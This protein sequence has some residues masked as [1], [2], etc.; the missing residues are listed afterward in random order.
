MNG[1]LVQP[2]F[3]LGQESAGAS[4]LFHAAAIANRLPDKMCFSN[5]LVCALLHQGAKRPH[6]VGKH[7]ILGPSRL[8]TREPSQD[9]M[10]HIDFFKQSQC[11]APD[12]T[13][14]NASSL[15]TTA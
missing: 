1:R 14:G 10:L 4:R 12:R 15:P 5:W 13:A 3:F 6:A 7:A 8:G 9:R 2:G 11:S